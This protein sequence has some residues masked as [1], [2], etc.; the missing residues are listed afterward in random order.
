MKT[1]RTLYNIPAFFFHEIC[2]IIIMIIFFGFINVNFS[3]CEC[4]ISFNSLY[5]NINF[6]Y[7]L[8]IVGLL[9][10][11]AP[12]I[13]HIILVCYSIATLNYFL[14]FYCITCKSFMLSDMDIYTTKKII[15]ENEELL[16]VYRIVAG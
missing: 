3:K 7:Y 2:H 1:L 12:L 9:S 13:G 11:I 14:L 8:G 6:D 16:F 5:M 15:K 10:T 4:K